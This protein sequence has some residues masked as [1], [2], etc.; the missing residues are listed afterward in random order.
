MMSAPAPG[1]VG[2]FSLPPSHRPGLVVLLIG[3]G[4]HTGQF[5]DESLLIRDIGDDVQ[6]AALAGESFHSLHVI[7]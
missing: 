2:A 3:L 5:S 4:D 7:L 1:S 6:H